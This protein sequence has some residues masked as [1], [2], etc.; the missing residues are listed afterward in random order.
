MPNTTEIKG[1][2]NI[3]IQGCNLSTITVNQMDLQQLE[4]TL[5]KIIHSTARPLHLLIVT[6]TV[7]SIEN[8][9]IKN[10]DFA[11]LK[12]YYS[13]K[14]EDWKP[15]SKEDSIL[16]L[17]KDYQDKSG[18][19]LNAFILDFQH[20]NVDS[21]F[22]DMLKNMKNNM[23]LV[24]D[25]LSLHFAGN[26]ELARVF[27]DKD[28]GGCLLPICQTHTAQNKEIMFYHSRRIFSS[29]HNFHTKYADVFLE[30]RQDDGYF[31]IDLEIADKNTLFRRLTSIARLKFNL[32]H[33]IPA[34]DD[35]P[36]IQ[37]SLNS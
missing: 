18:Y 17:L 22:I 35:I 33:V 24:L 28:I 21:L 8:E 34:F 7:K 32:N 20:E 37:L 31:Y 36:A 2:A 15:Y 16:K 30:Q 27:N 4:K 11:H 25:S 13:D 23:V 29:L 5:Q 3:V 1:D 12:P 19:H 26:Q 9:Q 10:L 6:T 14:H